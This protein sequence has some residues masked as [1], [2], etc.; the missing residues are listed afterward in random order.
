[1]PSTDSWSWLTPMH[2]PRYLL[3]AA[4]F[5]GKLYAI[6]GETITGPLSSVEV[7]DPAT[8]RWSWTASLPGASAGVE[9]VVDPMANLMAVVS[10]DATYIYQHG[11]WSLAAQ[12]IEST[13]EYGAAIG[14]DGQL[15]V[16]GGTDEGSRI[17]IDG[18]QTYSF[19]TGGWSIGMELPSSRSNAMTVV[20]HNTIY[21]LGGTLANGSATNQVALGRFWGAATH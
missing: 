11:A 6:G 13:Q 10:D 9:A 17:A 3:A 18:V 19:Q 15:Y 1:M 12:P 20:T 5:Q 8:S 14:P 7:Y 16:A 21:L 4:V 2:T